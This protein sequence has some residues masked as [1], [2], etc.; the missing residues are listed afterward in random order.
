MVKLICNYMGYDYPYEKSPLEFWCCPDCEMVIGSRIK[1]ISTEEIELMWQNLQIY[2]GRKLGVPK[3]IQNFI[4]KKSNIYYGI[5]DL[6]FNEG[7]RFNMN[8]P[9]HFEILE[10]LTL[11]Y[12]VVFVSGIYWDYLDTEID[13][14]ISSKFQNFMKAGY[15][16]PY[17]VDI[18]GFWRLTKFR[19]EKKLRG[20]FFDDMLVN[21]TIEGNLVETMTYEDFQEINKLPE[22]EIYRLLG[23]TRLPENERHFA[24]QK[25]RLILNTLNRH[26][27]H[28]SI[29][30]T[31]IYIET[32][33]KEIIRWKLNRITR[34]FSLDLLHDVDLTKDFLNNISI[35]IP[36]NLSF[37]EVKEFKNT[38][39]C[40]DFRKS[41][42]NVT[43]QYRKKTD[44]EIL[45]KLLWEFYEHLNEF[46]EAA[47]SYSNVRTGIL[48]G[49]VST[50]G[51]LL[52][53]LNSALISGIGASAASM[54]INSF[55]RKFYEITHK[56]WAIL[57]WK[58]KKGKQ[59]K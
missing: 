7:I 46:N 59:E 4:D 23:D 16:I 35:D 41:V 14:D 17:D 44:V 43:E 15:I 3:H 26:T 2:N 34:A 20:I 30:N 36:I 25:L 55:F 42:F 40:N 38:K 51:G 58:W 47:Q 37:D 8:I 39:A 6:T 1:E 31:P 24:P 27:I 54:L 32:D 33:A 21:P 50:I 5:I 28:A 53:G 19:E 56:D 11:L 9:I 49:V 10:T 18:M 52:E 57:L 13:I 48:T 12:D 29:L 22:V 45:Q